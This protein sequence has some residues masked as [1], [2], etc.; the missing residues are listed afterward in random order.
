LAGQQL[1]VVYKD[2][3]AANE[4]EFKAINLT[5]KFPL[6]QDGDDYVF[7]SSAICQH[8]ARHA[9]AERG[10]LGHNVFEA[11]QIQQWIDYQT[12]QVGPALMPVVYAAFGHKEVPQ[13]DFAANLKI[14][15]SRA[16]HVNK[17]LAGKHWMVGDRIS[18]AD[19]VCGAMWVIAF[20]SVFDAGF[21]KSIPN[22]TAWFER[23]VGL[24]SF[25]K[26][27]G[28]VKMT[29]KAMKAWDPNAPVEAVEE[30]KAPTPAAAETN[31]ADDDDL[32]L[33][34]DDDEDVKPVVV[35]QKKK[36]K[37]VIAMSLVMLEVKP[38]D[39]TTN[40]DDLAKYIF[41]NLTQ[42]GLFWK[43]EYK[44]EPVAFG[45]FKLIIG[46]SLEDDKVSVDNVV[47]RIEELED[48]V[49]SVEIAA[50]NKI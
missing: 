22:L 32:D 4:K 49:Q 48:R 29:N 8:L 41:A 10:L 35:I 26:A 44:K 42:D 17:A 23:C 27:L 3:A 40:L 33:F 20:Q 39:D 50:F 25:I 47:E 14:L 2:K 45:I 16:Q 6:L 43:T 28:H 13:A 1:E 46:F 15:K 36:K 38:L 11:A 12:G 5:G 18:V 34:G 19:V 37:V 31:K 24:P 7:E 30:V 9:P 21:R